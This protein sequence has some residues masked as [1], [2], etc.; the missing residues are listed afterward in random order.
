MTETDFDWQK[1]V[2]GQG[3]IADCD[4]WVED[5][6]ATKLSADEAEVKATMGLNAKVL[7]KSEIDI[8]TGCTAVETDE[9]EENRPSLVIYFTEDGDTLWDVAKKYGTT[10][11]KIQS[12]NGIE[13]DRFSSGKKILIP[14][15]C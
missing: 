7:K 3:L 13:T 9:A 6:A 12:A 11:E 10:V 8:I 14:R 5:I 1:N 2:P 15:A 4:L